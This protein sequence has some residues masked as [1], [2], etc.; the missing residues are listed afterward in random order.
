MPRHLL[1][2]FLNTLTYAW[3]SILRDRSRKPTQKV[4]VP[5][6][7]RCRYAYAGLILHLMGICRPVYLESMEILQKNNFSVQM[8]LSVPYS[9][10]LPPILICGDTRLHYIA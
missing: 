5:A 9:L 4:D 2:E 8:R 10:G 3:I 1:V 7:V 6:C